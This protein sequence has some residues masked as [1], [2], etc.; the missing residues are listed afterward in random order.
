M[1]EETTPFDPAE[2]LGDADGITELLE[3]ALATGDATVIANA[4]EIAD[5]AC[6]LRGFSLQDLIDVSDNPEWSDADLA[7]AR[8]FTEAFPELAATMR[9]QGAQSAR[10]G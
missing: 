9:D 7:A 3:L 10:R 2:H 4:M 6:N 8:P 5:R 1:S